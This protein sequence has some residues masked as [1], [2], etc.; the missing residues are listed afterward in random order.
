MRIG[1]IK[2]TLKRQ[3][4][5]LLPS[6]ENKE[7][8]KSNLV[9][10]ENNN[11]IAKTSSRKGWFYA[12]GG[13]VA[14]VLIIAVIFALVPTGGTGSAPGT[15]GGDTPDPT[16]PVTELSASQKVYAF[17]AASGGLTLMNYRISSSYASVSGASFAA[18]AFT[19]TPSAN[20]DEIALINK[21][22]LLGETVLSEGLVTVEKESDL[23][24]YEK[25]LVTRIGGIDGSLTESILYY[26]EKIIE[27]D[28]EETETSLTGILKMGN[29]VFEVRGERSSEQGEEE[30][31]FTATAKDGTYVVVEHEAEYGETEYSYTVYEKGKKVDEFSLESETENGVNEVEMKIKDGSEELLIF[32]QRKEGE[33][34]FTVLTENNGQRKVYRVEVNEENGNTSY[35]YFAESGETVD[36]DREDFS[37]DDDDDDDD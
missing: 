13:A 16:P 18:L 2:K 19:E 5:A 29:T 12:I 25:M 3:S 14:A 17:S 9:F 30:L 20:S 32:Y 22:M 8:I 36:M 35:R 24:D 28:E 31:E 11:K 6:E 37:D 34:Y 7:R 4:R 27:K 26:N 33:R 23:P 21:Y 1:K 10:S 15:P